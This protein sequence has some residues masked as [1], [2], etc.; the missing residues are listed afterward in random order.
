MESA[1]ACPPL[2]V[3]TP[4]I[5]ACYYYMLGLNVTC[6]VGGVGSTYG[7]SFKS[8]SHPWHDLVSK[9]Q[10]LDDLAGYQWESATGIGLVLGFNGVRALDFDHC[11]EHRNDLIEEVL[12]AL[13]LP[14]DYEWV[15]ITHSGFHIIFRCSSCSYIRGRHSA[16]LPGNRH[17]GRFH[18]Y[19]VRWE[20]HLVIPPT[21]KRTAPIGDVRSYWK[22]RPSK[23]SLNDCLGLD[24]HYRFR[25]HQFP[26]IQPSVVKPCAL[27]MLMVSLS[28]SSEVDGSLL[29]SAS[30]TDL[31]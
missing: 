8:P 30:S 9:K 2:V 7:D 26:S 31:L 5:A 17:K 16:F 22:L 3:A 24:W 18:R 29:T 25:A 15:T 27:E 6:I 1:R 11:T 4:R 21:I 20:D 23:E 12:Y 13:E 10:S 28:A 19:E 14:L